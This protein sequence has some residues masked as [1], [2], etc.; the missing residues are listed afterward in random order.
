METSIKEFRAKKDW[1]QEELAEKVG[2]RR[3]T[4]SFLERGQYNPSLELAH[5]VAAA[6]E[7]SID[8]IFTFEE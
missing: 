1:T 6:L 2:V 3:E 8:Q 4:I 5:K 7:G